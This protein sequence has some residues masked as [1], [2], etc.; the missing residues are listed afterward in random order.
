MGNFQE[1]AVPVSYAETCDRDSCICQIHD[2]FSRI[3]LERVEQSMSHDELKKLIIDLFEDEL[4]ELGLDRSDLV[5]RDNQESGED[6][7]G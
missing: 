4:E 5:D 6:G 2:D 1:L 7:N 3:A